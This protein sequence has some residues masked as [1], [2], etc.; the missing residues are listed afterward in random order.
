MLSIDAM[1]KHELKH[2]TGLIQKD[3]SNC[4]RYKNA[5]YDGLVRLQACR[6]TQAAASELYTCICGLK[7][8]DTLQKCAITRTVVPP[9]RYV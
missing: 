7:I 5:V 6:E 4:P 3:A 1:H 2:G 8:L 9:Q